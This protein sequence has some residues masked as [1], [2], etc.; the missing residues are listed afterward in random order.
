ASIVLKDVGHPSSAA[1]T[2]ALVVAL[3]FAALTLVP[4]VTRLVGSVA[5]GLPL[6]AYPLIGAVLGYTFKR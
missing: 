1:L 5:K 2:A 6:M 3:I 4:D